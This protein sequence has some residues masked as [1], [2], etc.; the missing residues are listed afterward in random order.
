[1]IVC[2]PWEYSTNT[3]LDYEIILRIDYC[4]TKMF[5]TKCEEG[6]EEKL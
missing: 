2:I 3:H 1:M 5:E 4:C 6:E